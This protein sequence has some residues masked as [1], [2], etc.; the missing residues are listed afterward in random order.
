MNF[1]H[2]KSTLSGRKTAQSNISLKIYIFTKHVFIN[3][4]K[5]ASLKNL[6]IFSIIFCLAHLP[7]FLK[8]K[9]SET[10]WFYM[11]C[12]RRKMRIKRTRLQ[13]WDVFRF[14][15]NHCTTSSWDKIKIKFETVDSRM[16]IFFC[17]DGN[18]VKNGL[19]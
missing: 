7:F 8:T 17:R 1:W 16:D 13:F 3:S 15:Q 14:V 4:T 5:E 11:H 12:I 19:L 9:R 18:Q 10:D 6:N 2:L